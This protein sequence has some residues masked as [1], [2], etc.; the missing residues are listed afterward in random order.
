M[1]QQPRPLLYHEW[2]QQ[3]RRGDQIGYNAYLA[4]VFRSSDPV[5]AGV[6]DKL[7]GDHEPERT[8]TREQVQELVNA[9]VSLVTGDSGIFISDRD[10]DLINVVVNA[11]LSMLDDNP[12]TTLNEVIERNWQPYPECAVC[13]FDLTLAENGSYVHDDP[14]NDYHRPVVKTTAA[15]VR[16]WLA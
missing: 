8:F 10:T 3:N 11:G 9:G 12:P 2:R 4:E 1:N 7:Y 5:V 14:S 15:I 6:V 13:S 16:G